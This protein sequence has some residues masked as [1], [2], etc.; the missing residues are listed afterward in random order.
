MLRPAPLRPIK[1]IGVELLA[2][3]LVLMQAADFG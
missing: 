2:S 1:V 3:L